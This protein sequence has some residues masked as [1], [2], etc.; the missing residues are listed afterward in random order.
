VHSARLTAPLVVLNEAKDLPGATHTVCEVFRCA[1]HDVG[2][3]A[4]PRLSSPDLVPRP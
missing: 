2:L 3:I 1:Q 4:F